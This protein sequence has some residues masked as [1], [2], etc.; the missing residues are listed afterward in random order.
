[1]VNQNEFLSA[2]CGDWSESSQWQLLLLALHHTTKMLALHH[3]T[4]MLALHHT[5]K[6]LALHHTI[7]MQ[8]VG[9]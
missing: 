3:T 7:K 2:K 8:C 6:M 1:M 9:H 4:K 5:T